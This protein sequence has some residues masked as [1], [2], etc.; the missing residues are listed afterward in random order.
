MV[1]VSESESTADMSSLLA[2][3]RAWGEGAWVNGGGP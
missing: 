1:S 2:S 3:L